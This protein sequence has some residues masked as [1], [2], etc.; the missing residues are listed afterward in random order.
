MK[1][2]ADIPFIIWGLIWDTPQPLLFCTEKSSSSIMLKP[3]PVVQEIQT[4]KYA[5]NIWEAES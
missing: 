5:E 1:F 4:Q 2:I 3:L